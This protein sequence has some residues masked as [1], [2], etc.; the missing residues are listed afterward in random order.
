M[1]TDEV[2]ERD[3]SSR[4]P[5]PFGHPVLQPAVS[6]TTTSAVGQLGPSDERHL[7][8]LCR[9]YEVSKVSIVLKYSS[10]QNLL[11]LS[12]YIYVKTSVPLCSII[13]SLGTS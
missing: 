11:S 7:G 10:P 6:V 3:G 4:S 9:L 2:P 13:C 12:E 5:F 1:L 8:T